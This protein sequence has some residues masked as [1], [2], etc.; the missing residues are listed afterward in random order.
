MEL[1]GNVSVFGQMKIKWTKIEAGGSG[2]I[3]VEGWLQL[4]Y[5]T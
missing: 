5:H 1:A 2:E 4:A 3:A